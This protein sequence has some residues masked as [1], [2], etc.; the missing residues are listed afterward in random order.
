MRLKEDLEQE[1]EV[2]RQNFHHLLDTVSEDLYLYPSDNPAWT[3]GDV[4]YHLTI[5]LPAIRFE[6]WMIRY[7]PWAFKLL[8]DTTS[9]TFNRVNALFARQPKR[10]SRRR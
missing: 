7:A 3:I 2:T 9:K 1:L 4:L 5:G 6:I 8:N 10:I